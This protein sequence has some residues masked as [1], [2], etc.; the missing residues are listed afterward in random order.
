[1]SS[2]IGKALAF[3]MVVALL[4][5]FLPMGA[6]AQGST[7]TKAPGT[8]VSSINIQNPTDDGQ[9]ANV[10]I[11]FYSADG[12]LELSFPLASAIPDGGSRSLFVPADVTGLPD[13]QY[14]AVIQSNVPLLVVANS[15]STNPSTAGA[16][17]GIDATAAGTLLYFPGTY[18]D[19]Y[20]FWS[21]L[22][23]QNTE[24]TQANVTMRFYNNAGALAHT[25]TG[26]IPGNGSRVFALQDIAPLPSG[27]QGRYS[28]QVESNTALVGVCNI[29]SSAMHGEYSD[30]NAYTTGTTSAYAPSLLNNYYGF[31]SSLTVQNID[32]T[33]AQIRVT[34]S[35]GQVETR[36]LAPRTSVEYY[37]PNNPNLPSGNTNGIFSAR[38]ESTNGRSIV[39]L[40]NQE[41]K[42]KGLLASYNAPTQAAV[43][44]NAP[45]VLKAFYGWFSAVTVQ[46]V[47]S[48]A[49]NITVTYSTG[50]SRSASNVPPN[51]TYNFIQLTGAGDPLPD[52]SSVSATVTSTNGQPLVVVV[53]ENSDDRYAATP[54][55]YLLAY[56]AVPAP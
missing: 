23:L 36:T 4:V 44:V 8:W 32:T 51:G 42:A 33:D 48:S 24:A 25:A 22:V 2:R 53:N 30:Y 15:S 35:N 21:E 52:G 16:Y 26:T 1:M 27:S 54:G 10:T 5:A 3:A 20:G 9:A 40:V 19:Y 41:D 28:V 38:V 46:N 45:V 12:N 39:V 7:T 56:T 29:W 13:G 34:Y 11:N 47:G 55:D 37:Q 17:N 18:K 6:L 50:H 14:S 49:A 31:V 43:T